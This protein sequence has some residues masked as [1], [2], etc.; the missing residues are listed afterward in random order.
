VRQE[1]ALGIGAAPSSRKLSLIGMSGEAVDGVNTGAHR[2]RLARNRDFIGAVEIWRASVPSAALRRWW[3]T[4]PSV[5]MSDAAMMIAPSVTRLIAFQS[6][7]DAGSIPV[8]LTFRRR[9]VWQRL[10]R[11]RPVGSRQV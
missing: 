8:R 5:A 6:T 3:S 2:D 11:R 7:H 4:R 10:L 1:R 9:N